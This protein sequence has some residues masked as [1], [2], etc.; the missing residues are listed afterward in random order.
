MLVFQA[1]NLELFDVENHHQIVNPEVSFG[2]L[3]ATLGIQLVN[4]VGPD[5]SMILCVLWF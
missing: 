2:N 4:A 3:L 1:S 5:G